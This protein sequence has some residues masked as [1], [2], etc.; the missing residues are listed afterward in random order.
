MDYT[1][2]QISQPWG[3]SGLRFAD[4][5]QSLHLSFTVSERSDHF[6]LWRPLRRSFI[7]VILRPLIQSAE[8]RLI[9][10]LPQFFRIA[11]VQLS[12][13]Q[14]V[15]KADGCVQIYL[16]A[17]YTAPVV[18][19]FLKIRERSAPRLLCTGRSDWWWNESL[20]VFQR[21]KKIYC[22]SNKQLNEL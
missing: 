15:K 8:S 6:Y 21:R 13:P 18:P 9:F 1:I 22:N 16:K 5:T 19:A 11:P 14:K 20:V 10:N 2:W 12:C 7:L 4:L 17:S 3:N